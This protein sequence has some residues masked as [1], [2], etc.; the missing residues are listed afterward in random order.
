MW[1]G[2]VGVWVRGRVGRLDEVG[3]VCRLRSTRTLTTILIID[4]SLG[5]RSNQKSQQTAGM[6][7]GE[8]ACLSLFGVVGFG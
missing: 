6:A 1:V 7:N 2:C 3:E 8:N 4:A 5:V